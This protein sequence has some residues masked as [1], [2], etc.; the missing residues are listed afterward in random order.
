MSNKP[1]VKKGVHITV[2][3]NVAGRL[4]LLRSFGHRLTNF[5][6]ELERLI[7]DF[8]AQ[9]EKKVGI[10]SSAWLLSRP[11]PACSS[12]VL[13]PRSKKGE[14]EPSFMGCAKFPICRHTEGLPTSK[15]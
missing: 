4:T 15:G 11:C 9:Q 12:G 5:N 13:V 6:D 2:D 1:N 14:S 7:T 10:S 3:K 8:C